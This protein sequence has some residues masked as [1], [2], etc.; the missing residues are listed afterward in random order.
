M[1]LIQ[2]LRAGGLPEPVRQYEVIVGG[3][4]YFIDLAF[5]AR[6]LA[7]ELDG[8]PSGQPHTFEAQRP[9]EA[10]QRFRDPRWQGQALYQAGDYA[11]AA[12][13]CDRAVAA[14]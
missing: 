9:A 11:A 8:L 3:K 7:I 14:K 1:R 2:L 13:V 5:P 6:R 4:R 12:Q 10:A